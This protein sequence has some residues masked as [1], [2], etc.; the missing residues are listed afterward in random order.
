MIKTIFAFL[1]EF[2][3]KKNRAKKSKKRP[4]GTGNKNA[5]RTFLKTNIYFP[6]NAV[7]YPTTLDLSLFTSQ[8]VL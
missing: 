1:Y 2:V 3:S 4:I 5:E 7:V 6:I 8:L